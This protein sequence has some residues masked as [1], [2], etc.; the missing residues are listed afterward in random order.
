MIRFYVLLTTALLGSAVA[1]A[2]YKPVID[3]MPNATSE[4]I[5][6]FAK[7]SG[8]LLNSAF[9]MAEP[10]ITKAI[11]AGE[12][13]MAW[14]KFMNAANPA[15]PIALTKPGDL[16]SIPIETP[17]AY[18]PATV[19]RDLDEILVGAPQSMQSIVFE[20]ASFT[21]SPPVEL[22]E[23]INWARKIDKVYQTATRWTLMQP[24]LT[25]L[26]QQQ[27]YDVRGYYFLNK[28]IDLQNKL[29]DWE[30]LDKADKIRLSELLIGICM[31][32][33]GMRGVCDTDL[34]FSIKHNELAKFY[35][36][37][38]DN[39]KATWDAFFTLE[40]VRSEATWDSG[41][42]D[43]MTLPFRNTE[44]HIEKFLA[45]NIEDEWKW[46]TWQLKLQ[47]EPKADIHV[48]FVP[49]TTPHVNALAGNTITMDDN[50]PLT[51]WDVQW[52]IRHEY[53]HVLGFE[54]CYVEYYDS[55]KKEM[56]NY[57]LDVKNLMCS[58]AG[59]LQQTHFD[60]MKKK[61][62]KN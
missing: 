26:A 3:L 61:Y 1:N 62:F 18:S 9:L 39:A 25:Q 30:S 12:R 51:E 47:F 57:Q 13:N 20:N 34:Q 11:Q 55:A 7:N 33:A 38:W 28:E 4:Q 16:S 56:V 58:R 60:E 32:T 15:A 10:S 40:V 50:A 43:L 42:P 27:R 22:A 45:E 5:Q 48:E 24:Y 54:D 14:L 53:G 6:F 37:Y 2:R 36:R 44:P 19:Q 35:Q 29:A 41:H 8:V 52:T 46:G 31:N 49:G 23:Y 17:K 59:R 21:T